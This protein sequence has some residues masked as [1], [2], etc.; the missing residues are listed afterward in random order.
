MSA[1]K[2]GKKRIQ[3]DIISYFEKK[4][5]KIE[6][7]CINFVITP[8]SSS[9]KDRDSNDCSENSTFKSTSVQSNTADLVLNDN[10]SSEKNNCKV[11]C[12]GHD[13]GLYIGSG[14]Q[15]T[16]IFFLI[17]YIV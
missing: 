12:A 6:N 11:D 2:H 16:D 1:S 8:H 5:T 7:E 17:L 13:F 15:V 10:S 9:E 4:K 3:S 14:K